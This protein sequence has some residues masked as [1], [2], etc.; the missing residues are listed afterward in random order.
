MAYRKTLEVAL[1]VEFAVN[2]GDLKSVIDRVSESQPTM[3]AL[4]AWLT[5]SLGTRRPT[6]CRSVRRPALWFDSNLEPLTVHLFTVPGDPGA[7]RRRRPLGS[8]AA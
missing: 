8:N 6:T 7:R 1:R 2:G 5:R 4:S 3:F